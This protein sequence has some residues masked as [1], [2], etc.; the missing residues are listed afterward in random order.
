MSSR[1]RTS[2]TALKPSKSSFTLKLTAS[3]LLVVAVTL[4]F[5][6]LLLARRLKVGYLATL[7]Q[8]LN[9]QAILMRDQMQPMLHG[10]SPE[11]LQD[12]TRDLG[13][14]M[15]LRVTL[16]R[17]DGR[18]VGDS[19]RSQTE[20]ETMDNHGSRPEVQSALTTGAGK[21]MRYSRTLK[22]DMLYLAIPVT[23]PGGNGII[24]EGRLWGTLR[25]A[26]PITEV[27]RNITMFYKDL[28]GAGAAVLMIVI[29]ISVLVAHGVTRPLLAL[30][31]AARQMGEGAYDGAAPTDSPDEFGELARAFNEMSR[32]I[33]D[34]VQE[35][36][37]ERSQLS[38]ILASLVEG[39]IAINHQ[40]EVILLN[41]AAEE[42]FG[43]RSADVRGRPALEVLRHQPLQEVLRETLQ[44]SVAVTQE[45]TIHSPVERTLRVQA[46]PVSYGERQTGVLA[47]LYD[48]TDIRRLE[49]VRREFVANV[50]HELKTPLTAIKGY[51]DTLLDGALEDP[52]HNRE[53][54]QIIAEHTR[55]LAL[56]IDDVLDLSAI[57]AKRMKFNFEP[58]SIHEIADRLIKG[59]APMAK[60]K[61]VTIDNQLSPE[62]PKVRADRDKLAQI[63]MNLLD[64][65]IKF[66]RPN[67]TIE[68]S[69]FEQGSSLLIT[70]RDSGLGIAENDLPR[71]FERFY[72]ADK[73]HSHDVAGTG[74][75]LAIVKHLAEAHQGAITAQSELGK[76]TTFTLTLPLA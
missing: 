56:L 8:S 70:I 2:A 58:V 19:E 42:L 62:L 29:L 15:K 69:A 35:L 51:V 44:K 22:E 57:E 64:N 49:T 13:N 43:V 53:F 52:K 24:G 5:T 9:A 6:G 74:L 11:H 10:S 25:V 38:G 55:H 30:T 61:P 21:S 59:L 73:A 20:L 45:I 63:L 1:S 33:Q 54:L 4:L 65:A 7:E 16:I 41:T 50:S 47:A 60:A 32:R 48:I 26:L 76:G 67:G 34:K 17:S 18:V 28:L 31:E 27:N 3:T 66:N 12:I 75:G 36:S 40:G 68:L 72:R 46:L 37:R 39:V 14:R 71:I 23:S